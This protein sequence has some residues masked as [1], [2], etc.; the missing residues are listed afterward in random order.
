MVVVRA[1]KISQ[2]TDGGMPPTDDPMHQLS[3]SCRVPLLL[4]LEVGLG[5]YLKNVINGDRFHTNVVTTRALP[6]V[7]SINARAARNLHPNWDGSGS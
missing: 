2:L 1:L 5:G 6:I 7:I 3:R 4:P